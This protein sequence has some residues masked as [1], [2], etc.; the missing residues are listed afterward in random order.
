MMWAHVLSDLNYDQL[1]TGV[2]NL[3]HHR[4]GKGGNDFPPNAGQF[5]DLC[6]TNFDWESAAHRMPVEPVVLEDLTAKEQRRQ[7]GIDQ[8]KKLREEIGL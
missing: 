6:L 5:R 3:I 4:D 7:H 8:I 1:A 2:K